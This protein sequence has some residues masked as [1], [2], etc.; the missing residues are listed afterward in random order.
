MSAE[1]GERPV[2]WSLQYIW[3]A[4][5]AVAALTVA[6]ITVVARF[7]DSPRASGNGESSSSLPPSMT[8]DQSE[9]DAVGVATA[10]TVL[11]RSPGVAL[12]RNIKPQT[13]EP[14]GDHRSGSGAAWELK[15]IALGG[16]VFELAYSCNAFSGSTGGLE[17]VLGK[18]YRE[19]LVTIGFADSS[20]STAHK[21]RFEI[22][23]DDREYLVTPRVLAFGSF[24]DLKVDV[25]GVTKLRLRITEM[26]ETGGSGSPSKPAFARLALA[27]A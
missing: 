2:G 4:I 7:D 23:G 11:E 13:T 15:D 5:A 24:E 8:A 25:T 1:P 16:R 17:F 9:S 3:P 10:T 26:S 20:G 22:V 6:A 19:L 27:P 21:V 12:G 18:S 14:C